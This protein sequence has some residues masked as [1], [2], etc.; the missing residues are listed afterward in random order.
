MRKHFE[1]IPIRKSSRSA[2]LRV[3]AYCRISTGT[4][5]QEH[6]LES[7]IQYFTD[8]IN[9]RRDWACVGIFAG[10][11]QRTEYYRSP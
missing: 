10:N 1:Q 8:K 4:E 2:P 6:S 9:S 5:E 3:S 7:Q 11:C